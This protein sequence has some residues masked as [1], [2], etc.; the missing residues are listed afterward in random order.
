[1]QILC[2]LRSRCQWAKSCLVYVSNVALYALALAHHREGSLD[3][4][5]SDYT[6]PLHARS[7]VNWSDQELRPYCCRN[8]SAYVANIAACVCVQHVY[9]PAVAPP[10]FRVLL[11]ISWAGGS[12]LKLFTG[13]VYIFE[14]KSLKRR[15]QSQT[16][17]TA[18]LI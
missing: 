10:L 13:N 8:I 7:N 3:H 6:W 4:R 17:K 15:R 9:C 18:V 5:K 1:M 12:Y 11:T 2:S 16:Q 14:T